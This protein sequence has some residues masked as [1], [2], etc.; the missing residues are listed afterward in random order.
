MSGRLRS[1]FRSGNLA[2][3]LG[4]LLLKGVAAVADVSRPEDVGI[5]AV[6][7]LL[8]P[9][10]D[11]NRY[12]EDSFIVQIK[13]ESVG[14]IEYSGPELEWVTRQSLPMFVGRV[15][16]KMRRISLFPTFNVTWHCVF[17]GVV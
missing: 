11:G 12:A 16:L 10:D 17:E 15:S 5:D 3:E 6:A 8:R 2:E 14:S 4:I 13:A 1:S 7:T 9:D